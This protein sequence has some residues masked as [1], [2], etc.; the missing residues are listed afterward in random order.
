MNSSFWRL[1]EVDRC[2]LLNVYRIL[3]K[4]QKRIQRL[5]GVRS[6]EQWFGFLH[7]RVSHQDFVVFLFQHC[8]LLLQLESLRLRHRPEQFRHINIFVIICLVIEQQHDFFG[9][10]K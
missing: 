6:C 1:V 8:A 2:P 3:V 5:N 9:L 4:G 10:R 7:K